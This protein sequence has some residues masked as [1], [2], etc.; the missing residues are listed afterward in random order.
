[1]ELTA[2]ISQEQLQEAIDQAALK[3]AVDVINDYYSSYNS[4]YKKAL[5]EELE[6]KTINLIGLQLP[7]I[8]G[9]INE[10]MKQEIEL[11]ANNALAQTY[12]PM[13]QSSIFRHE[14]EVKFSEIIQRLVNEHDIDYS[15]QDKWEIIIKETKEYKWLKVSIEENGE[16]LYQFT[17]HHIRENEKYKILSLPKNDGQFIKYTDKEQNRLEIPMLPAFL[18]DEV[19]SFIASLIISGSEIELDCEGFED[20]MFGEKC[21]C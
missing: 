17:M 16:K 4:P 10:K 1:M 14:K 15:N 18:S 6:N 12:L 9:L 21:Y 8:I 11:I 2:K 7:D 20:W 3:G 5:K 19:N 13:L